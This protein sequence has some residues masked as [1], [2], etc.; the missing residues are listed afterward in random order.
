MTSWMMY[1][2]LMLDEVNAV[3]VVAGSLLGGWV[4]FMF[5]V[6]LWSLTPP[7]SEDDKKRAEL[8]KRCGLRYFPLFLFALSLAVFT[9]NTKQMA[10]IIVVPKI[11]NNKQVQEIPEKLMGLCDAWIEDKTEELGKGE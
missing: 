2:L 9:P 3:F 8:G 7:V 1:W 5:C 11:I 6:W 10:A 4:L